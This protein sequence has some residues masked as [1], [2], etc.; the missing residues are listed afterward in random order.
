VKVDRKAVVDYREDTAKVTYQ[1][2]SGPSCT[3]G[4]IHVVGTQKVEPGV[5][6]AEVTWDPGEPFRQSEL[7]ATQKNLASLKLFPSVRIVEEGGPTD[8]SSTRRSR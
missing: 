3:F 5:V 6:E 8:A 4:A 2:E 1:L 7:D